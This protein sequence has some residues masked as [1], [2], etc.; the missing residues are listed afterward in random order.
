M[1]DCG[2]CASARD[3]CGNGL[4]KVYP[5]TAVRYGRMGYIG[6]FSHAPDIPFTCGGRVVIQTDR[7]IEIGQQVSLT[8]S[9]CEQGI[10]REQMR[11]YAKASGN[12]SYRLNNGHIL[13]GATPGDLAELRHID[14]AI[15]EKIATCR[16]LS[17]QLQLPMKIVD[18]EHIFG[19]ERII[20]YF[21]S[22]DRVDFRELVRMLARE[23][24]TRIEMRQ[25]GARDEARLLADYETCGRECCCK[26]FLKTLK[27]VGMQM[28]KLQKAT[29]DPSKVSGRCGRLKCCLRYEHDTYLDLNKRLPRLGRRVRTAS[30]EG[31]VI[32]RQVLTQLLKLRRDDGVVVTVCEED[33]LERDM[34][35]PTPPTPAENESAAEGRSDRRDSN[36]KAGSVR[37]SRRERPERRNTNGRKPTE[38]VET[39]T[40]AELADAGPPDLTSEDVV[41]SDDSE[42]A[43]A[44]D[45]QSTSTGITPAAGD[46]PSRPEQP[47]ADGN[48]DGQPQSRSRRSSSRKN[49]GSRRGRG[50]RRR[51][52]GKGSSGSGPRPPAAG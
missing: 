3:R 21:M 19:G 1:P 11:A 48:S 8:C 51:R 47:A 5:T 46:A 16:R 7:G 22:E 30:E 2:G 14:D 52:G 24:Q 35:H 50:G 38:S 9:S 34:P 40:D 18:A 36:S 33:V 49:R 23:F 10:S 39:P 44:P 42:D 41:L 31:V 27:P 12:D 37:S 15:A 25:V 6:E 20:F 43:A 45:S 13:R 4:E 17:D 32:D 29:L 28:A 26:N